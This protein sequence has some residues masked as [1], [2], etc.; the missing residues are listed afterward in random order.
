MIQFIK[1]SW[2]NILRYKTRSILTIFAVAC[3]VGVLFSILSFDMGFER[4]LAKEI[5]KT[6]IDFMIVSKGCSFEVASLVLYGAVI[7]KYLDEGLLEKVKHI[8]DVEIASPVLISQLPNLKSGRTDV[9]YGMEMSDIEKLKPQWHVDGRLPRS[10]YELIL[11][12]LIAE[13][14]KV[15]IGDEVPY[16]RDGIN[17]RIVGVLNRQNSQEDSA[18]FVP[19]QTLQEL[20][21]RPGAVTSIGVK[22]NNPMMIGSVQD[23]LSV[24]IPGIQIIMMD[25]V[26]E[27][28]SSVASSARALTL[29]IAIVVA[30]VSIMGVVD[31]ILI[32]LFERRREIGMMRAIGASP[33]DIFRLS[34]YETV[35][36]VSAGGGAGILLGIA[37]SGIVE[38][39]VR[40]VTPYVPPGKIIAFEPKL[41]ILLFLCSLL[42]GVLAGLY[43]AWKSSRVSPIE[44]INC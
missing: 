39:L 6:G 32:T 14:Y 24:K 16:L 40:E 25:E 1:L 15:K 27:N 10:G 2:N 38:E 34:L 20:L 17:F 30:M 43:P 3:S 19:I 7:P 9:V 42:A 23:K 36:L 22:T 44:V 5:E 35:I 11:G 8:E 21:A 12:Y 18:V 29:T 13:K 33:S 4:N 31:S 28:I 26:R 41:G 37:G